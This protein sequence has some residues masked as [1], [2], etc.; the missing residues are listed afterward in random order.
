MNI[1]PVADFASYDINKTYLVYDSRQGWYVAYPYLV[2]NYKNDVV[3]LNWQLPY[4]D[5]LLV[6]VTHVADL[7]PNPL[8]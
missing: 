6:N 8:A 4:T 5:E 3:C 1:N 7:P 2:K